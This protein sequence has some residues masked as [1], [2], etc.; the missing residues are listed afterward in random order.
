MQLQAAAYDTLHRKR[1]ERHGAYHRKL[2]R[3]TVETHDGTKKL[4]FDEQGRISERGPLAT[5]D[6][7]TMFERYIKVP[8]ELTPG[9]M[10][11][12]KSC[13]ASHK[14]HHVTVGV[15]FFGKTLNEGVEVSL[16]CSFAGLMG[17]DVRGLIG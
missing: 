8:D 3:S 6:C 1:D 9:R 15:S 17:I 5:N 7:V 10:R 13:C 16:K 14:F 11:I 2:S 4:L 12:M